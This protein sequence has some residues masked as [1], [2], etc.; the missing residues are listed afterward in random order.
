[1]LQSNESKTNDF[2]KKTDI[3][4]A[5]KVVPSTSCAPFDIQWSWLRIWGKQVAPHTGY[6]LASMA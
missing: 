5:T 1:M 3:N 4:L 2:I 6:G